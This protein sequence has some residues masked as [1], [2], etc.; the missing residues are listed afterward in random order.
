MKEINVSFGFV[1]N[2]NRIESI[3]GE[4][5]DK[6]PE[7]GGRHDFRFS[8]TRGEKERAL[9][10]RAHASV[11]FRVETHLHRTN[12]RANV[13]LHLRVRVSQRGSTKFFLSFCALFLPLSRNISPPTA[14]VSSLSREKE[15]KNR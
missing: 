10:R 11:S 5:A 4:K 2:F 6:D 9:E 3:L 1:L 15:Q 7:R 8:T 14:Y 13:L 12:S